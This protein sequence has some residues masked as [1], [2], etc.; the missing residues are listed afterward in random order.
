MSRPTEVKIVEVGPRDGLQNER[1]VIILQDK[2]ELVN[3]LSLTGL[4]HIETGS[5][6]SPRWVPQMAD[7]D[8]VFTKIKRHP[9]VC[10]AALTPNIKGLDRAITAKASEVAVF[11]AASE[12]FSQKNINCSIKESLQRSQLVIESALSKG[13]KVRGYISC[14]L[15]CPYEG[16]VSNGLNTEIARQLLAMGCYEVSLGDT[17]GVGTPTTVQALIN[18]LKIEIPVNKL[19]VHFHDTY[20]QALANIFASLELGIATVDSS[21]AGLGGCPYAQGASGNIATEDLVYMLDGMNI[22]TGVNLNKLIEVGNT[23]CKRLSRT[24]QSKVALAT[25][26]SKKTKPIKTT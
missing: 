21:V 14:A 12:R 1:A 7:S 13:L 18:T 4:R 16:N 9:D 15:G 6:V 5:F 24:S 22:K 19:A 17:L 10:Y 8:Q 11:V 26:G 23:I 3:A 20:G 2:V 25:A